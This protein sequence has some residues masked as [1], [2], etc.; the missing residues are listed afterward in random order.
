MAH[1]AEIVEIV[2]PAEAVAGSRVD[3]TVTIR[4]K[5]LSTIGILPHGALEYGE[6]PWPTISFPDGWANVAG[7]QTHS[8]DGHFTMLDRE[9]KIHVYSYY[10]SGGLWYFDDEKTKDVKVTELSPAFSEFKIT[11]YRTV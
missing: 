3:I 9:V 11:D 2:A 8:F 4:N 6:S 10:Y 5:H 7:G 1:Y